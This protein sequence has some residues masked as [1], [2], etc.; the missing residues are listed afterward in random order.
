M[1]V[2][3]GPDGVEL[4]GPTL[5]ITEAMLGLPQPVTYTCV[6]QQQQQQQQQQRQ[7]TYRNVAG[8]RMV[9]SNITFTVGR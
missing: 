9:Q 8:T 6:A 2:R 3:V 7:Q 1:L 4:T 5:L